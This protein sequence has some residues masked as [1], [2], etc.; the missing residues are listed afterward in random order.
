VYGEV[1]DITDGRYTPEVKYTINVKCSLRNSLNVPLDGTIYVYEN[2]PT[3]E[4]VSNAHSLRR[5]KMVI[6]MLKQDDRDNTKFKFDNINVQGAVFDGN[7]QNLDMI[8]SSCQFDRSMYSPTMAGS[9]PRSM[10]RHRIQQ[11]I[12]SASD[13]SHPSMGTFGGAVFMS[14]FLA[15]FKNGL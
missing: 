3:H 7:E 10:C 2:N 9:C 15:F 11:E 14:V 1:T 5:G 4:C 12:A 8:T 13:N 6:V